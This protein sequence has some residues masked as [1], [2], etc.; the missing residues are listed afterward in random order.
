MNHLSLGARSLLVLLT[1]IAVFGWGCRTWPDD[2]STNEP[3]AAE[4]SYV[5]NGNLGGGSTN[6]LMAVVGPDSAG[7]FN[8]GIRYR[9]QITSFE[10]IYRVTNSDSL[11]LRYHRDNVLHRAWAMIG[12]NGLSIHFVEP[13]GIPTFRVN[14]EIGGY[15]MSGAW[16]GSMSSTTWQLQNDASLTMDQQGQSFVGSVETAFFQTIRFEVN[17]GVAN[18]NSFHLNATMFSGTSRYTALI[19]GTYSARDTTAGYWEAGENGSVDN[20]QF[21]FFRSFD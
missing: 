7:L 20:G 14:R 15:N 12:N 18:G 11:W 17:N 10:D 6:I 5:G 3:A 21:L 8:G 2:S 4:G 16:N 9:S 13:T 1:A 19:Y